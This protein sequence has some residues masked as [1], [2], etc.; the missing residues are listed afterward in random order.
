MVH[1]LA[2]PA[3]DQGAVEN[4]LP[5]DRMVLVLA[6]S[7]E[8]QARLA[9]LNEEQ[10]DPGS[11]LFHHW[12]HAEQI[13][14]LF[15]PSDD[16][17]QKV[18]AW[19]GSE[20]FYV[21]RVSKGRVT[22]EFSGTAAQVE[23]SF[24]TPVHRYLVEG[25]ERVANSRDP[26]IPEALAPVVA[27]VFSLNSFHHAHQSF[28][29][30]YIRRDRHT[31]VMSRVPASRTLIP[32]ATPS[33]LRPNGPAAAGSASTKGI[34]P[35]LGYIDGNGNTVEDLTPFDVATIYSILPLW[36]KGITG[37]GVP[38]AIIGVSDI[39]VTDVA[40]FRKSF[41]LP[42]STIKVIVDG[43]DPGKN[44][45]QGENT[46]DVEMA[47]AT[48]PGAQIS[49]VV[50]AN[51]TTTGGDVLASMYIIDNEVAPI[52][53]GSYG[54]C[55][56]NLGTAG[57]KMYNQLWQQ[58]ATSGIS[59]F[60]SSGDQGSAGCNDQN[61]ATPNADETGLQVNGIAS[62]PYLTAVGGTDLAW[63][64]TLATEPISAYWNSS[65]N[66]TT[67]ASAK[68]YMPE[69]TWNS[70]C[71]NPL[72]LKYYLDG[73]GNPFPSS[74]ALCNAAVNEVPDLVKISAG[75]GGVSHC[76]TPS[77]STPSTCSGGYAKPSWQV[78]P[79]VPN[80]GKRDLPDVSMFAS[81]GFSKSTSIASSTLLICEK[82]SSPET[83]C[84]YSDPDYIIYQENGGTS[85][86]APLTAGIMALVL[87]RVGTAQGLANPVFY[88]L[89]AKQSASACNSSTVKAGN[90]CVFYDTTQGSNTQVCIPGDTNCVTKTS[91][92]EVGELSGFSATS[93]YDMSTGLGS[94]NVA[95]LVNAWP[96]SGSTGTTSVSVTPTSYSFPSTTVGVA[97]TTKATVTVKNTGTAAL[98]ISSIK[99][100][101][102]NA[103][104]FS[105][106]TTCPT[107]KT[108]AAGASCTVSVAFK[109]ASG[110][111]LTGALSIADGA[112]TQTVA[113]KGTGLTTAVSVTPTSATFPST[114]VGVVSTTKATVTVKNTGTAAL[115]ISSIKL[116]GTNASSFSETT[117]CPTVK[118]LA[119]GASCTAT[120][121]FKPSVAGALA[122]TLSIADGA[123]TQ[124]IALKGTAVAAK[125]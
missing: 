80:D 55:E 13:G 43:K 16:D 39:D 76:T 52:A 105:E 48:A 22:I 121:A 99:L 109:P 8:Q 33:N 23:R 60:M 97:S 51:T 35:Q 46:E 53:S 9:A 64:F 1:P 40:T 119:A 77:G 26:E 74:E 15:G 58:A 107:G 18:T 86:A 17:L 34:K 112:G 68:G 10:L 91:G 4:S 42:A 7:D 11:P 82:S 125:P 47:S 61:A 69:M 31:G 19:L 102:T 100:G 118:T 94:F 84:D 111:A 120:V 104:S 56:L 21:E 38:L 117:T 59:V 103:S 78:A 62:S 6:R 83:S 114:T 49:L 85:A 28:R 95:N 90:A 67:G 66:A 54:Q 2:K 122:A 89:A 113:L 37:S 65:N 79:G 72:L 25:V 71:T 98:T 20:G 30:D 73:D 14:Q 92:D 5:L 70:T 81:Y 36:Q 106:T 44:G 115:T 108:L 24:H 29:G 63:P 87:Q 93:G 3:F 57:N 75:S 110:G 45:G 116:G 101:G 12:L 41:G 96:T 124:N 88:Q 123:G 32:P 50:A 27:G